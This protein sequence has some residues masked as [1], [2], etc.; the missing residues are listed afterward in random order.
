MIIYPN[1]H[2]AIRNANAIGLQ[3]VG[4][5][6]PDGW[7]IY[8]PTEGC[9][10]KVEPELLCIGGG[11]LPIPLSDEGVTILSQM[12]TKGEHQSAS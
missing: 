2:D 8:D 7:L 10:E 3:V 4:Y 6:M 11:K 12:V 5:R 1:C 9:P